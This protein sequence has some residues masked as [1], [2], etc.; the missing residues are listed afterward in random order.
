MDRTRLSFLNVAGCLPPTGLAAILAPEAA[1][2]L[3]HTY[4][5]ERIAH[6]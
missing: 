6:R 2:R 1:L 3:L 4:L 5:A